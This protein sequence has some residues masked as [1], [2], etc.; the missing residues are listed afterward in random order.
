MYSRFL[1]EA[2]YDEA[3]LAAEASSRWTALAE[4]LRDCSEEEEPRADLWAAVG[5][6][7]AAVLGAEEALWAALAARTA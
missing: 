6:E 5:E 4:A 1:D 7:A 2:G 3:A